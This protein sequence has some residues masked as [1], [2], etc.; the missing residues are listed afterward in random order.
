MCRSPVMFGGGKHIVNFG[1]SLFGS[2][3]NNASASQRAYQPA[4]TASGSNALGISVSGMACFIALT[5]SVTPA[6]RARLARASRRRYGYAYVAAHGA[7]NLSADRV[8]SAG[9]VVV[10]AAASELTQP[11]RLAV[12]R[13]AARS[14]GNPVGRAAIR[15][16]AS[17]R[18]RVPGRRRRVDTDQ[19][20]AG[21]AIHG[22]LDSLPVQGRVAGRPA[23]ANFDVEPPH[24]NFQAARLAHRVVSLAAADLPSLVWPGRALRPDVP[25][26]RAGVAGVEVERWRRE[27]RRRLVLRA[28]AGVAREWTA[29][30]HADDPK[31]ERAWW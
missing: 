2:A 29:V 8:E 18:D 5:G 1:L 11:N 7:L 19:A 17:A 30:G 21:Q 4:S 9:G 6:R 25:A 27:L 14:A 24:R 10:E 31:V 22:P 26:V 23:V 16:E 20:G 3:T 15:A 12:E 28:K 13:R